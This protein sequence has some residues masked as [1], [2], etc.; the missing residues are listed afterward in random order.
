MMEQIKKRIKFKA[1]A[2]IE[3]PVAF[4][5][6]FLMFIFIVEFALY[7]KAVHS[8]QTFADDT[9]ANVSSYSSDD[10]EKICKAPDGELID[11]I[12]N[13]AQR[14]LNGKIKLD[15]VHSTSDLLILKSVNNNI[16]TVNIICSNNEGYI[17]RSEYKFEG[18]FA[19]RIGQPISSISS[20]QT[21]RF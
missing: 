18:L 5:L 2:M 1:Q 4:L 14:Y 13:R 9:S 21:P 11:I 20:V 15:I 17:V 8:N 3:G 12:E 10:K 7:F 19:L 16:L 6:A